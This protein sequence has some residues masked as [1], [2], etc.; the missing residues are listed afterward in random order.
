[1]IGHLFLPR[2]AKPP[3]QTV[4]YFPGSGSIAQTSSADIDNYW[5]VPLFVSFLMQNGRAVFYPVYKGTFER[6][7]VALFAMLQ[8]ENSRRYTDYVTQVVKDVSRSIDYLETR[9]DID[10]DR[11]AYY[12][13]S[14]GALLGGIAT[15]VEDRFKTAVLLSGGLGVEFAGQEISYRAE[16]DPVNYVPRSRLPTLMLNGR[17]DLLLPLELAI[18]PLYNLLGTPPEHKKLIL[19][20]TDHIPPRNEFI[21]EIL[22]WL[23]RYLGPVGG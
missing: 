3:Y 7:D 9:E 12:G 10:S 4:V 22:A 1:M 13:L 20:D 15:S 16:A 11:L 5:E 21:K 18:R 2:N 6:Q 8:E 14:W 19:Y 23:D 17:Y